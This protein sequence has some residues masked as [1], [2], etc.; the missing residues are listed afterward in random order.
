MLRLVACV[1]ALQLAALTAD[2]A[3]QSVA[4]SG[5]ASHGTLAVGIRIAAAGESSS[6]YQTF[7]ASLNTA[8]RS[9]TH[10]RDWAL[11]ALGSPMPERTIGATAHFDGD[12]FRAAQAAPSDALV[13]WLVANY[14]DATTPEGAAHRT[15]ALE[16]LTRVE[17]DNGAVWMQALNDA[18]KRGDA[19]AVDDA[20]ARMAEARRFDDHFVDIVHAWIDV[21]DRHPPPAAPST[22][23]Y[24]AGFVSAF[25]KAAATA[26]PGYNALVVACKPPAADTAHFDRAASC[27]TVGRLMLQRGDTLV[28]RSIGFA[29]LRN[30]DAATDAERAAKR[31]LDWYLA[32]AM[33]GTGE[34]GNSSDALAHESDWRRMNDE[35]DVVKSALHRAGLPI[36]A[37]EGWTPSHAPAA[38]AG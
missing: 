4:L 8:M 35:I 13:Q 32:N 20:L 30:L 22:D 23:G 12:L 19:S 6:P 25:A 38:T 17:P 34:D 11:A 14:A 31:N 1:L 21:Y 2:V 16:T 18:A 33:R 3:A 15:A 26:M 29:I 27:T 36:E 24:D 28:A 9:S 10:P 5:R 37:P 7:E